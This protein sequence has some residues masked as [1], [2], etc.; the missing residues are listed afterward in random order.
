MVSPNDFETI[1]S[2]RTYV[3]LC[4]QKIG[5][6]DSLKRKDPEM[7]T[8]FVELFGRHPEKERKGV[9]NLK[10]IQIR[11]FAKARVI[12]QLSDYQF[13]IVKEDGTEDS[14]SWNTC[15]KSEV[16]PLGKR[17]NWAMR[18]AVEDQI[19][20]FKVRHR[21][22][23]CQLCGSSE[24]PTVDHIIKFRKLK[25][26]FLAANPVHPTEF[27]KNAIAQEVFREEDFEFACLWKNYHREKAELRV[28][29]LTCNQAIDNYGEGFVKV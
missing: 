9:D 17:L 6:T 10:D 24:N 15:V 3:L 25:D 27:A 21:G 4:I 23:R 20:A 2:L 7:F 18:H 16:N 19:S 8:F 5:L 22:E 13:W 29:C 11:K 1:E 28:L 26:D 14:I 12:K